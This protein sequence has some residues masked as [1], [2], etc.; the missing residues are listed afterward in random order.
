MAGSLHGT[1]VHGKAQGVQVVARLDGSPSQASSPACV[2]VDLTID[3]GLHVYGL[4]VPE[5][6]IPLSV[7]VVVPSDDWTI[8]AP[9]FP[10]PTEHQ[11]EGFDEAFFIYEDQLSV[12]VP[13]AFD[14]QG[15]DTAL[16]V[17]VRYQA[18]GDRGCFMPQTVELSLPVQG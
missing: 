1:P 16:A 7:T 2:A 6:F 8:G 17:T 12:S 11:M 14:G 4:P 9:I 10:P 18:C 3:P 15:G 13:L 5:G